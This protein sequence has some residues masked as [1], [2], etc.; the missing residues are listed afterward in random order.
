[1]TYNLFVPTRRTHLGRK[2]FYFVQ[3]ETVTKS[4]VL[5]FRRKRPTGGTGFHH[6]EIIYT[7]CI[8]RA[9]Q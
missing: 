2:Q 8:V 9:I 3:I 7:I 4:L 1:M 6:L 5:P